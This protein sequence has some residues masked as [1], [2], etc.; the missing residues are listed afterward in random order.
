MKDIS[1]LRKPLQLFLFL[2]I[3]QVWCRIKPKDVMSC[4]MYQENIKK[5]VRFCQYMVIFIALVILFVIN[6]EKILT[7]FAWIVSI[8]FPFFI[9]LGFAFVFN[10][11]SNNLIRVYKAIT[12]KKETKRM[13]YFRKFFYRLSFLY[14][15]LLLSLLRLFRNWFY[16]LKN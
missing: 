5:L 9:G 1:T 16:L 13:T 7:F 4:F 2:V 11:I 10:I 14:W 6:I 12:K 8:L 3:W 15:F